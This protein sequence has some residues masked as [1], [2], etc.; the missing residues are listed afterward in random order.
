M[1]LRPW[2]AFGQPDSLLPDSPVGALG[3]PV[4]PGLPVQNTS[5]PSRAP[6]RLQGLAVTFQAPP[7]ER[8]QR[9]VLEL[10]VQL[11]RIV[12]ELLQC[13]VQPAAPLAERARDE[14]VADVVAQLIRGEKRGQAAF[15]IQRGADLAADTAHAMTLAAVGGVDR[16]AFQQRIVAPVWRP[17]RGEVGIAIEA[18]DLGEL[19]GPRQRIGAEV[20]A[21]F[22]AG[23]DQVEGIEADGLQQF[24]HVHV[25]GGQPAPQNIVRTGHDLDSRAAQIGVQAAG[26]QKKRLSGLQPNQIQE[27]RRQN[28]D[29]L[30]EMIGQAV[31]PVSD[32]GVFR[33]A[34]VRGGGFQ[35]FDDH[36]PAPRGVEPQ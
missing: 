1:L 2:R 33:I 18:L 29:I 17:R 6:V 23:P 35:R 12:T 20:A 28:A 25:L 5:S 27:C 26:W 9:V 15:A 34:G 13:E 22:G 36:L 24:V 19:E 4:V 16:K 31:D 3:P 8:P 32:R 30:G 11:S 14:V 7:G 21:L 10:A